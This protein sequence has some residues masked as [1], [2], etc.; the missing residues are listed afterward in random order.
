MRVGHAIFYWI[1]PD[2]RSL[3]TSLGPVNFAFFCE[4]RVEVVVQSIDETDF[5]P[6]VLLNP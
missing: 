5:N 6:Q 1:R 2:T 3:Q 4:G